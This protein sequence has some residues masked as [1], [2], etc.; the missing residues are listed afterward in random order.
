MRQGGRGRLKDESDKYLK[1]GR[2]LPQ[3]QGGCAPRRCPY[4]YGLIDQN[5]V[6]ID[7]ATLWPKTPTS[8]P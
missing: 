4:R 2:R 5:T 1:Q 7:P 8:K 3:T 6:Q